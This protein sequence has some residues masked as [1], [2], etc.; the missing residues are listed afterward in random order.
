M[1]CIFLMSDKVF[2]TNNQIIQWFTQFDDLIIEYCH[3]LSCVTEVVTYD[4]I[5][6]AFNE[7]KIFNK[8]MIQTV[9]YLNNIDTEAIFILVDNPLLPASFDYFF[10]DKKP[11][12][13]NSTKSISNQLFGYEYFFC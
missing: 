4:K 9:E 12:N 3:S 10:S 7:D 5:I 2:P 6:I 8:L 13:I 1:K 11:I